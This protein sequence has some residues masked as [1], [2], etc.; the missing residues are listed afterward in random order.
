MDANEQRARHIEVLRAIGSAFAGVPAPCD[1]RTALDAAIS[2]LA[3][4]VPADGEAVVGPWHVGAE[5]RDVFSGYF[6]LD[7]SLRVDGDFADDD[8][9]RAYCH[10]I[11]ARLNTYT[12]PQADGLSD[13]QC[14]VIY[15]RVTM[16]NFARDVK[17][18]QEK[19]IAIVRNAASD[20]VIDRLSGFNKREY[21]ATPPSEG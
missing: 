12:R 3:Q 6:K 14:V 20:N 7:V 2:A 10:A 9:L 1:E 13:A 8:Q 19:K 11:A 18:T 4:Q 5:G 21:E 17:K 16:A 15:D